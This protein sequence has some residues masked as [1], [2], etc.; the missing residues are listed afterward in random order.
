MDKKER[1]TQAVN[2]LKMQ[3]VIKTQDDIAIAMKASRSNVSAAINGAPKVLTD[4][5][6]LRFA[7]VYKDYLSMDWLMYGKGEMVLGAE[8]HVT[9]DGDNKLVALLMETLRKQNE[10]HVETLMAT[11]ADKEKLIADRDATIADKEKIIAEKDL[12]IKELQE[13]LREK[14]THIQDLS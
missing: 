11:I 10:Q 3:G 4:N 12:R 13:H 6:I 14:D 2:Y 1:L 9:P 5:F 8:H 7:T